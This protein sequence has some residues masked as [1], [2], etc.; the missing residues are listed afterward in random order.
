MPILVKCNNLLKVGVHFLP[1]SGLS[2]E[3]EKEANKPWKVNPE[4]HMVSIK[5]FVFTQIE[6]DSFL[7]A[8]H[9]SSYT[10]KYICL[11]YHPRQYEP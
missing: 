8:C 7:R 3:D 5:L 10:K 6:K 9:L 11:E 1:D 4:T 2:C